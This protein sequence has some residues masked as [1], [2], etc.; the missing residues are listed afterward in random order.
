M[1]KKQVTRLKTEKSVKYSPA[2]SRFSSLDK[3]IFLVIPWVLYLSENV[4][5][6]VQNGLV[7]SSTWLNG[8]VFLA[9]AVTAGQSLVVVV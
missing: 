2:L 5:A 8:N 6:T 3:Q 1:S 4:F 7:F 9:L